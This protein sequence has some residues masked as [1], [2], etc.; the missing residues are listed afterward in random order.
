MNTDPLPLYCTRAR[1][2]KEGFT[3]EATL[4]G[5]PMWVVYDPK[6][7]AHM[8]AAAKFR[9]LEAW[10]TLCTCWWQMMNGLREPGDE[11]D[12]PFLVNVDKPLKDTP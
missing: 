4:F 3:H 7:E 12:F 2:I 9:P 11:Q 1:A 8:T 5:V 6:D 10:I